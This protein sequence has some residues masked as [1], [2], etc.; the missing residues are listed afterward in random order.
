MNKRILTSAIATF[1]LLFV[2]CNG[3]SQTK[4]ATAKTTT[5][6]AT[7]EIIQFHSEHR[8]M[9]CNKIEKLAR[10]TL[11]DFS[12]I[13]F[14]LVNVDDEKNEKKATQFEAIGTALFLYNPK[15][16]KKKDLTDF[17]FMNAGDEAKFK[18]ELKKEI[19]LFLKS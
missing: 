6:K 4:K 9:T 12:A 19:Q 15:T 7:I 3:N 2:S 13:P 14:S 10:L 1:L 17:A 18:K 16:G 5:A 11:K 8:C